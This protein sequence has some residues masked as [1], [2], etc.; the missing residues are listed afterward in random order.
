MDLFCLISKCKAN[1]ANDLFNILFIR[2]PATGTQVTG[3]WQT[4]HFSFYHQP[5][6][7]QALGPG[8]KGITVPGINAAF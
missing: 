7:C 1:E 6:Q 2:E 8:P 5:P 4:E 3:D